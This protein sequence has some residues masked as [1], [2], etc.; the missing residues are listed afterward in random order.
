[1]LFKK[2]YMNGFKSFADP[3]TIELNDGITCVVGPNG[4]GK[5]NISDAL[6]WVLGE[7]SPKQLR[8]GKMEEVIFAGTRTRKPKGMAEVTLTIDNSDKSLPIEYN[9]VAVTRRM[10]RSGENEYIINGNQC[11]LRDIREL[12]MDTGIGVEGYSIIGQGKIADLIST[13]PENR[14]EVFEEAAGIVMYKSRRAEAERKLKDAGNNLER[15]RDIISEIEGRI[16]GLR[17]DSEKAKEYIKLRDRYKYLE[18]NIIIHNIEGIDKNLSSSRAYL[19][20][21]R[22]ALLK[23]TNEL[24]DIGIE[25]DRI[26]NKED[27]INDDLEESNALLIKNINELNRLC[28]RGE[29]DSARLVQLDKDIDRL[30]N[31]IK[32]NDE[33]LKL[34]QEKFN[35][36]QKNEIKIDD[37]LKK[38]KNRIEEALILNEEHK[39][40]LED[41]NRQ[42]DFNNNEIIDL[43]NESIKKKAEIGVLSNYLTT[44]ENR[45][46]ETI[47]DY[48]SKDDNLNS[49]RIEFERID[50][51]LK[52]KINEI[53][54]NEEKLN[55]INDEIVRTSELNKNLEEKIKLN[56]ESKNIKESRKNTLNELEDRY[57]GYNN[58]VKALMNNTSTGI[59]GTV[60]DLISV[61]DGYELAIETALGNQ[62]QSIICDDDDSAKNA[63]KWLKSSRNGRATFLP[64]KSIYG[65]QFNANDEIISSS[66]YLGIA[67]N[68]IS[69]NKKYKNIMD[70]LLGRIIITEKLEDAI[71]LSKKNIKASRIVT[72]EGEV[73]NM[74]GAI[75]GGRYK[76]KTV[77]FLA[78]K[79]EIESLSLEID[80]LKKE[81]KNLIER[82]SSNRE[83]LK[84]LK[85]KR[86]NIYEILKKMEIDK[87][88]LSN[89]FEHINELLKNKKESDDKFDR[90]IRN[91]EGDINNTNNLINKYQEEIKEFENKAQ[92]ISTETDF[93]LIESEKY[94]EIIEKENEEVLEIH[95]SLNNN[96]NKKLANNELIEQIRDKMTD[97]ED[98]IDSSNEE[99][100]S[101]TREKEILSGNSEN[102]DDKI[103][104][105]KLLKINLEDK[106]SL[107]TAQLEEN[108]DSYKTYLKKQ[109]DINLEVN[110]LQDEIH[111]ADIKLAKNETIKDSLKTKLWDEFE[112]SYAEASDLKDENLKITTAS[113][114]AKE[115]KTRLEALGDVN[116][117]S[118][119]EYEKVSK[120]YEFMTAQEIDTLEA[121]KEL[122][123]IISG[124][125]KTIKIRFKD[126]FDKVVL[127]FEEMFKKL[128][129]GGTAELRLEDETNPLESGIDIIAQPPGKKLKNINLMSGGEKTLIGVALMF[130][131]LKAKPTPFCILDEVEAALDESNIEKFGNCLKS[132]KDIQ[133][134][135]ITH[136]KKTMEHGDVLYGVTMPEQ[137]I[138]KLLSLKLS[139]RTE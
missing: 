22:E 1:M 15:V 57:E 24:N 137:G 89:E 44:L 131:V 100:S 20:E 9:E 11:R 64:V 134:A 58:A 36:L 65:Q 80:K 49:T 110:K 13:K 2:I 75:T 108:K 78:R 135:I 46:N 91:I 93:L 105:L 39:T 127:N 50:N 32:E 72:L 12:F 107:A 41:I 115:V 5:S 26:R 23:N 43:N 59:I 38:D 101:F 121:I 63:V 47:N 102:S 45:K 124:I 34:E 120:R 130:A 79:K 33:K 112:T 25:L 92:D 88:V 81:E 55:R 54:D 56:I 95:L 74:S 6:R 30:K 123:Q 86:V 37:D 76:H 69:Y 118:I 61:P 51:E 90:N 122:N 87:N 94:K 10:Y 84:E 66:G 42:I 28:N 111:K 113:K 62:M 73:I 106:I 97:Y 116:I 128:F 14:R 21:M 4:T 29:L 16:D 109:E 119:S 99:L 85:D 19:E 40:K 48:Q 67:S 27:E 18:I 3:V 8:G 104:E 71:K 96:Q 136:Q 133:F 52:S 70:Y 103:N 7:Q 60:S 77:N 53:K 17:E 114:E 117:G 35:E 132:F 31:L 126:N 98:I 83:D 68:I 129:G 82:L 138:S 125:E 139:E